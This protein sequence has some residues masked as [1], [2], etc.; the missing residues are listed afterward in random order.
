MGD[1]EQMKLVFVWMH[2]R[3]RALN[4]HHCVI[5]LSTDFIGVKYLIMKTLNIPH[6]HTHTITR[7][8]TTD[9]HRD[10][11]VVTSR[12]QGASEQARAIA[13]A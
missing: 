4:Q 8:P 13:L 12:N 2:G 7:T 5:F 11:L 1:H 3:Q 9:S 6:A 10:Q